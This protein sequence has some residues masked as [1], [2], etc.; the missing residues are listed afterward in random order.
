MVIKVNP[1]HLE[2]SNKDKNELKVEANRSGSAG[3]YD[4]KYKNTNRDYYILVIK[5]NPLNLEFSSEA[6]H[7]AVIL[8]RVPQLRFEAN[9]STGSRLMIVHTN[10][11]TEITSFFKFYKYRF[12]LIFVFK[13]KQSHK[14]AY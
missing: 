13:P 8:H 14:L 4:R 11:Q 9:R 5:F 7:I 6:K 10:T 3:T 1:L 12:F 2:F